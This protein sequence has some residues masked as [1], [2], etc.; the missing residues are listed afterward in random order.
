MFDAFTDTDP[1]VERLIVEAFARMTPEERFAKLLDVLRAGEHL[2][3]AGI[4]DRHGQDIGEEEERLRMGALRLGRETMVELFGWDPEVEGG[5]ATLS[6][7]ETYFGQW[8][9]VSGSNIRPPGFAPS[10]LT[11]SKSKVCTST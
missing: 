5:E 11:V 2:M 4:R 6:R 9:S 10:A 7:E 3:R 1:E 8:L